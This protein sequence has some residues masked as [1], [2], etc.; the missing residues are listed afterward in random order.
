ML[1]EPQKYA[2]QWPF[3]ITL[4]VWGYEFTYFW[5]PGRVLLGCQDLRG[6]GC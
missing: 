6:L 4:G 1:P 5:G 3:G 2:E